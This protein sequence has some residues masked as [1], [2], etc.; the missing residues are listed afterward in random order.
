MTRLRD[1]FSGTRRQGRAALIPYLTAGDP[2]LEATVD[3]ASALADGGAD[4][5][6]L[7][8]PFSDPLADGPVIQRATERALA[9]GTRVGDVLECAGR[10]RDRT[11][12]PIVIMSYVNPLLRYGWPRFAEEAADAGVVGTLLTDVPPEEAAPFRADADARDLGTV[13][14]VAPTS[15][16]ARIRSAIDVTTGF[17]YCVS[18]LGVTGARTDLSASFLPVL[19]TIRRISDLPIGVGFGISSPEHARSAG[20]V[21]DGVVVGS[22]LVS[23]VEAAASPAEAAAELQRLARK[24]RQAL[25]DSERP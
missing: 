2:A 14:L 18:R 25:E 16:E 9:A 13:F 11:G 5:L 23:A 3:F 19:Q 12:L 6:E 24:L 8:V 22:R 1:V 20:E 15:G 4:I 21:A 10:I 7:G 17:L